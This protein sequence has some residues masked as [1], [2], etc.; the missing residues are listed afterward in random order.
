MRQ[1]LILIML[2]MAPLS[3]CQSAP[4][5]DRGVAYGPPCTWRAADAG[6]C[7]RIGD[8]RVQVRQ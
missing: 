7:K 2:A 8:R 1:I 6:M 3:G 4:P 5:A